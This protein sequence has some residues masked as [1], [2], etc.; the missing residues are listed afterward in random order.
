G[1]PSHVSASLPSFTGSPRFVLDYLS[2]EVLAQ[3]SP[4]MQAFLL[5]TSVLDRLSGPLCE[6]VTG[7]EGSQAMLEA[8][9]EANLFVVS[10]DDE[11]RWYRFHYLFAEVLYSQLQQAKPDLVPELHRRASDWY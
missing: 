2:D 11:R 10:L 6:A 8:L 3:Q 4:E 9:E 7:Q 5:H 1:A